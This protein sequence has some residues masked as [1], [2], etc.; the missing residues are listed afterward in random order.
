MAKDK[1]SGIIQGH[2][3]DAFDA[4]G[5]G[6][7]KPVQPEN[8]ATI[9]IT[10]LWEKYDGILSWGKG[11]CVA[12]VDDGCDLTVPEWQVSLPWGKKVLATYN[13]VDDNDDPTPVPPGYHGTSVGYASSLCYEGLCAVA[14]NDY[15]AQIRSC[16]IVH[17]RQDETAT[18]SRALRWV[19]DNAEKYNITAVNLS[20]LDDEQHTEPMPTS[21]DAPL[22]RLRAAGI[23]V[24][25][26]CGNTQH[27]GGISWPACQP[28]CYGIGSVYE[29]AV[30]NDRWANTDILVDAQYTSS[31]N[32]YIVGSYTVMREAVEKTGFDWKK[33]GDNLPD[34]VMAIYKKTGFSLHDART[35]LDFKALNLLAAVDFVFGRTE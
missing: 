5:S 16:S 2:E 11:Q 28:F 3:I 22:Q 15:V 4:P 20:V 24:S 7:R 6:E 31:S 34:A 29:G 25:S 17:L 9:G 21:L 23:W 14:Y 10:R 26:P 27:T 19:A 12:I 18:L 13:S 35:G 32:G 1:L 30:Y 33:Y 8:F